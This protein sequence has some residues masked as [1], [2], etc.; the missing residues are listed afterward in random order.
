MDLEQS[1]L[2]SA[3]RREGRKWHGAE[4]GCR[5]AE[6]DSHDAARLLTDVVQG[7][8]RG[9]G[10]HRARE[11][12]PAD[13]ATPDRRPGQRTEA[14]RRAADHP[15]ECSLEAE[16]L[17]DARGRLKPAPTYVSRKAGPYVPPVRN[18]LVLALSGG[19]LPGK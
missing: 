19:A 8:R 12:R 1:A 16:D 9:E 13:R 5:N 18:V 10:D 15:G 14:D 2:L 17:T 7:R 11:E 4:L 3:V 6:S